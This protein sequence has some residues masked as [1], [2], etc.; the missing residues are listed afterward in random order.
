M[1]PQKITFVLCICIIPCAFPYMGGGT[2]ST[3]SM[4]VHSLNL[5]YMTHP[6]LQKMPHLSLDSPT[7]SG[8]PA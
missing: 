8:L 2:C 3:C 7:E 4:H 6:L 5:L 1:K